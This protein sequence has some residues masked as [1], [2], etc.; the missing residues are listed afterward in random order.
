MDTIQNIKVGQIVTSQA[1]R[2]NGHTYIV[3]RILEEHY[4]LVCDGDYRQWSQPK[5]KN[6]RHLIIHPVVLQE[7]QDRIEKQKR[8]SDDDIRNQILAWKKEYLGDE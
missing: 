5:K 8:I 6:I 7:I 3:Q 1:G 4:V 2:D